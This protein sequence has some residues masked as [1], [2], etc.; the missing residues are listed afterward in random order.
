MSRLWVTSIDDGIIVDVR[1][2][3]SG[4]RGKQVYENGDKD[5]GI[6]SAGPAMG[7][8]KDIPSCG[9]LLTRMEKE[10]EDIIE[11]LSKLRVT[12]AKL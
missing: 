11:G 5:F 2:L 8:I 6:W 3:V 4:A 9:Q 1:D 12:K 7:L 10:A